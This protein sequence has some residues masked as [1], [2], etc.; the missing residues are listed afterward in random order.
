MKVVI[1]VC[2]GGFGLSEEAHDMYIVESGKNEITNRSDPILID[3]VE[4]LG[5]KANDKYAEL[6]I[7]D[8]PKGKEFII[9]EY[10][11]CESINYKDDFDWI[12]AT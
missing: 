7:I 10:G 5:T 8:I 2:F 3:I 4:R 11:G 12:V 1:N 9:D 6:E